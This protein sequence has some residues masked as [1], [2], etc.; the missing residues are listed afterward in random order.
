MELKPSRKMLSREYRAALGRFTIM[1]MPR[2]HKH[3]HVY[4]HHREQKNLNSNNERSDDNTHIQ[5]DCN[6]APKQSSCH[7]RVPKRGNRTQTIN[8][9]NTTGNTNH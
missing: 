8:Q 5:G 6:N 3:R 2:S 4:V 7:E 1:K 9:K